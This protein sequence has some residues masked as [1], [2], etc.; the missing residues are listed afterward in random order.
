MQNGILNGL[1]IYEWNDGMK[2]EGDH[3]NGQTNGIGICYFTD[4]AIYMGENK[5]GK[6]IGYGIYECLES[7]YEGHY[8]NDTKTGI[9]IETSHKE[10][11]K[12]IGNFYSGQF[13]GF[14]KLIFADGS[15]FIGEWKNGEKR[16]EL[17]F[18]MKIK[19]YLMQFGNI[20]KIQI[21]QLE[22]VFIIFLMEQNKKE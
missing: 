9:G 14:G 2:Y 19:D 13:S 22:K 12:Y 20:K 6:K 3:L 16:R 11:G 15:Y 10:G 18:I 4:G 7:K 8:I 21:N 1:G 17:D 5:I